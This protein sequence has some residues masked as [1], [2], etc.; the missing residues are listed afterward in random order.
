[1]E[2]HPLTALAGGKNLHEHSDRKS[3]VISPKNH[4]MATNSIGPNFQRQL[5]VNAPK[6]CFES[7]VNIFGIMAFSIREAK[8]ATKGPTSKG[9]LRLAFKIFLHN[10][11]KPCYSNYQPQSLPI[12]L[13]YHV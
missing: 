10:L 8:F 7:H 4:A 3:N 2:F 12:W 6:I 5:A 1:M 13:G 9:P 11:V